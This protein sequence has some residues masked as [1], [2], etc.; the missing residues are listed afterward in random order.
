[1]EDMPCEKPRVGKAASRRIKK[2]DK[3]EKQSP[4]AHA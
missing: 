3:I 4:L 1:M 2:R